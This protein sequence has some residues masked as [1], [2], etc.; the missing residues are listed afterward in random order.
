V[1]GDGAVEMGTVDT[2]GRNWKRQHGVNRQWKFGET[3]SL[4]LLLRRGMLEVYLDDHFMECWTMG[5]HRAKKV[6]IAIP[7]EANDL[8]VQDLKVWQMT[9]PGWKE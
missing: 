4:C 2:S 5:C 9:L 3:A 7:G 6:A 1:L 8:P